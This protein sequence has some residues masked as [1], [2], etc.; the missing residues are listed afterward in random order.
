MQ[1]ELIHA[2]RS[3]ASFWSKVA[4]RLLF[5]DSMAL[6]LK[7]RRRATLLQK[8]APFQSALNDPLRVPRHGFSEL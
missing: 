4:C 7:R 6:A 1:E 5:G 2:D 8:L 3:G